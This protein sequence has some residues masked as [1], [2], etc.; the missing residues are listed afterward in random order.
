MGLFDNNLGSELRDTQ[1]MPMYN[2]PMSNYVPPNYNLGQTFS[3]GLIGS[4]YGVRLG[5][6]GGIQLNSMGSG[7]PAATQDR[8]MMDWLLGTTG[9]DGSQYASGGGLALGAIGGLANIYMGM[10]NDGL[11]KDQLKASKQA[12][13]KNYAAQRTTTNSYLED[14]QRARVASNPGAYASVSDY[15]NKNRIA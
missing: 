10:Q 6:G 15:M 2:S 14:R 4:D 8:S 12:Y 13:E 9:K 5:N 3:N 1:P 7:L 11:Q